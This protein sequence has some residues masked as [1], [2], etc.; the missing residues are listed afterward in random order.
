MEKGMRARRMN[1]RQQL[2]RLS[3]LRIPSDCDNEVFRVVFERQLEFVRD[4]CRI[5]RTVG[6]QWDAGM[7]DAK[8]V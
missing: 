4:L 6:K 5:E 1:D 7:T 2:V 8:I 3:C